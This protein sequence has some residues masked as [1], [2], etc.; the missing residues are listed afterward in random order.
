MDSSA[1][2]TATASDNQSG[3]AKVEFYNGGA[4]LG[5]VSSSPYVYT[6]N[7]A[8]VAN[9]TYTVTAKAHDKAGN[10]ASSNTVQITVK[11]ATT[12]PPPSS[13]R[14]SGLPWDS[15]AFVMHEASTATMFAS[16]RGR[17][18]DFIAVAPTRDSWAELHN[19]WY[20]DSERIPA[21]FQ[22][23][24]EVALPLWPD[25]GNLGA[26]SS[27]AYNADWEKIARTISAK[28]PK[29]IIRLGWEMNL[30]GWPHAAYPSTAEQWKQA[31][32]L[33][34]DA[35]R[36]GGSQLRISWVV[37][38]GRGQT[39]TEDAR[40][41]YPGDGYVDFIGMDV[42]DWWP[43]YTTDAN[44]ATHRDGAYG[45]NFW[46]DFAKSRGKKF[47]LGEWGI[48]P[49]NSNGGGDNPRYINFVYSWLKA[50][51]QWIGYESYFHER[52]GYLRSDL[53]T[54]NPRA[55]A[56]YKASMDVVAAP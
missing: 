28:Y 12:P 27:G 39:G 45:W 6:W 55:S 20:M 15:G 5:S 40:M 42:Y 3:V 31:Y 53:F 50:N 51:Q 54:N 24:L 34:V 18:L 41:F 14:L 30:P 48:A 25:N 4:L 32:R 23:N 17:K 35:I 13:D 44:V 10:S 49:G 36:R 1:K 7:T 47:V 38:E 19:P 11:H 46:L 33:A 37:N 21:G 8:A 56:E 26:A 22:G 43:P 29:A 52:A 16:N 9:G 2:L